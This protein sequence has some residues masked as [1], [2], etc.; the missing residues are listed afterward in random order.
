MKTFI[1]FVLFLVATAICGVTS[2]FIG[3][4]VFF[5][6]TY[7]DTNAI[8]LDSLWVYINLYGNDQYLSTY[9]EMAIAASVLVT[10]IPTITAI[11]VYLLTRHI[12][13]LHGSA[14]FANDKELK[15]SGLFDKG[16][17]PAILVGKRKGGKFDGEFVTFR[18]QQFVGVEAPTRSGKGV[19]IVI[20]NLVTYPDSIVCFDIKL[21]NFTKSA[22]YRKAQGQE[23][24]LFSPDGY[25]ENDEDRDDVKIRSHRWNAFSYIRREG[26][27]RVGDIL[28][29]TNSLYPVTGSKDD[30]WNESAGKLF[31]G[32]TLYMLDMETKT[33][34]KPT[35]PR[36]LSLAS[37]DGGLARWM[38]AQLQIGHLSEECSS[39]FKA[40][41]GSAN[42]TRGSILTNF[43]APLAIFSDQVVAASVSDDDFNLRDVR[44]KR[45]TIY[46][47]VAPRNI[48][49]FKKLL[50]LFFEQLLNENT[51]TLPE[52]NPKLK[53]QCLCVLDEFTA[54][55]RINIIEKA[56]GFCA[57]Y[58]MRLLPI[59]QSRSQLEQKNAYDKEGADI[60]MKN[61]AIRVIYPPKEVDQDTKKVSETLGYKTVKS[62]SRS[63]NFG[64]A[65]KSGNDSKSVSDQ[66]RALMMPQEIVELGFET[67]ASGLGIKTLLIKENM[68]PFIMEK[69]IYFDE[70][71]F[72]IRVDFA[73]K[74]LPKI[75]LLPLTKQT[76][77]RQKEIREC[78]V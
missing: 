65:S 38:E 71:D 64:T 27:Y 4:W 69:I 31:K 42:E 47:G 78:T 52:Q 57:G 35:F 44:K 25:A 45:M 6:L 5:K 62:T 51:Q 30:I 21:E 19:G 59:F 60:I 13:E 72:Q 39:E 23:V 75:P 14:R 10:L 46:V 22:G 41:L 74:N 63:R 24:F 73:M 8:Q 50:N 56:I 58:N 17:A 12:E 49:R 37:P 33:G 20:P 34:I 2:Q 55:G 70:P 77:I 66:R 7:M 53:Y 36:L 16:E 28:T 68:R 15:E 3:A 40:F 43:V 26:A 48:G 32:L 18:G 1:Y 9:V 76:E 29:M 61:M 54:L 67:H 11:V